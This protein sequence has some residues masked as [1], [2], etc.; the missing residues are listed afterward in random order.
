MQY[1]YKADR[2]HYTFLKVSQESQPQFES[3]ERRRLY[4]LV[5]EYRTLRKEWDTVVARKEQTNEG[6]ATEELVQ[7]QV[8][9]SNRLWDL[10]D[11]MMQILS[12]PEY[13]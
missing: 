2:T 9:I 6:P 13:Q 12:S 11:Q 1:S 7:R 10:D 5:D 3:G 8:E 4:A